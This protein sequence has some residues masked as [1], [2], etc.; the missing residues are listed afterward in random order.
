MRIG[1]GFTKTYA[2]QVLASLGVTGRIAVNDTF[3]P[4]GM[5]LLN[6]GIEMGFSLSQHPD[7]DFFS[8]NY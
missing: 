5:V 6:G 2:Q 1:M 8:K 7:P 4:L 3:L